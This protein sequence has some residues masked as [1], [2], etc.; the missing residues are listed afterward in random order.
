MAS[1]RVHTR[2]PRQT[3]TGDTRVERDPD[4]LRSYREDAAHFPGGSPAG[5]VFPRGERDIAE[6]V[7][8][9]DRVLT[10]GAQ[11][12]LTGGATPVGDLIIS[13]SRMN[14]ILE[15]S[16][17]RVRMQPGVTLAALQQALDPTGRDYPPAPTFDGATIGGTVATNAAGAATF[18]YG[19]TRN[20]V[21]GLVVVLANGDTLDIERGQVVLH[22]DGYFEVEGRMG[23]TRVPRPPF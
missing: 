11:S 16:E 20:W 5:I 8:A 23:V 2:P 18:K 6:V 3:E 9:Y 15:V 17:D 12:S 7:T 14:R 22:P 13:T 4:I 19:S 10:I 1:H 21:Q